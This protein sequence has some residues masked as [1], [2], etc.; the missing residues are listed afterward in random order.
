MTAD[1]RGEI[2]LED[3]VLVLKRIRVFYHIQAPPEAREIIERV[4]A[5]HTQNCPVYRSIHK[6]IDITTGYEIEKIRG[7]G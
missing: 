5:I 6:A 7:E 2:E 1:I 3:Q 4:H